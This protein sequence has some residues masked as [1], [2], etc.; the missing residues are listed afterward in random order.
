MSSKLEKAIKDYL[1]PYE[2]D[3]NYQSMFQAHLDSSRFYPWISQVA[4]FHVV[5]GSKVLSSGCGS[6]GDL[7][8][9]MSFGASTAIGIDIRFELAKMAMSRFEDTPFKNKVS[10]SIYNGN[11]LPFERETFD[12]I[13]SS[14][15]IEHTQNPALYLEELFRVVNPGGI[16]FLD[17]PNRYF[18]VEQHTLIKYIHYLPLE[19]RDGLIKLLL[20]RVKFKEEIRFRLLTLIGYHFPSPMEIIN[21]FIKAKNLYHL[22]LLSAYFHSY[23]N[24]KISYSPRPLMYLIGN[25]RKMSSFRLVIEKTS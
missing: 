4:E 1:K 14:H 5:E 10:V 22:R 11:V 12:I 20:S 9:F 8:A 18:A 3:F 19:M 6:G 2:G 7:F 25:P 23:D 21:I 17:L 24:N 16:I 15:V 13:F